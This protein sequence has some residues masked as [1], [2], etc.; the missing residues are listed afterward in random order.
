MYLFNLNVQSIKLV[1]GNSRNLHELDV[2]S[3]NSHISP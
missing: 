1:H 3:I 2:L